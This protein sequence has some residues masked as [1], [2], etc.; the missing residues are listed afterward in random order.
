MKISL[1]V[2]VTAVLILMVTAVMGIITYWNIQT[3]IDNS[4]RDMKRKAK[5]VGRVFGLNYAHSLLTGEA[6]DQTN[7][8]SS[9]LWQNSSEEAIFLIA[10][11]VN[12]NK[13]FQHPK[14]IKNKKH[15]LLPV[16]KKLARKLLRS[17]KQVF[18]RWVEEKYFYDALVPI[19]YHDNDFGIIR[20][21]FDTTKVAHE[22][23]NI[24]I[25]NAIITGIF[26]LFAAIIGF[27][28]TGKLIKPLEKLVRVAKQLGDGE[29]EA[30]SQIS[31]GDEIEELGSVFNNMAEQ[32]QARIEEREKSLEQLHAIQRVGSMLN[33][34]SEPEV[35]FSVL[36]E[37]MQ[38]LYD[39]DA[40][41]P[42]IWD[43]EVFSVP[44]S[45]PKL[46]RPLFM[47]SHSGPLEV[48]DQAEKGEPLSV[49]PE[50]D[51]PETL[52]QM[53]WAYPLKVGI[54]LHGALFMKMTRK[55]S[56][57]EAEW[58]SIWG[59]QVCQA[60]RGMVL[61]GKIREYQNQLV[62]A[63]LD[64]LKKKVR[65]GYTDFLWAEIPDFLSHREEAGMF[66]GEDF[67]D[68]LKDQLKGCDYNTDVIQLKLNEFLIAGEK[69]DNWGRNEIEKIITDFEEAEFKIKWCEKEPD[70]ETLQAF[71]T[72]T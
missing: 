42:F 19:R 1:K 65:A 55:L 62:K 26:W 14:K 37:A 27:W 11:D 61:D 15:R 40:F 51:W 64:L 12:G 47:P 43:G 70:P 49:E 44:Y 46:D 32:I 39:V 71:L 72:K 16:P 29:L 63:Q 3:Q 45:R 52:Q 33:E 69:L 8:I 67:Y 5:L 17:D 38:T 23:Q 57:Q 53:N 28:A 9:R 4:V 13:I 20:L 54:D 41:I 48:V 36:D 6:L 34:S 56:D 68:Q 30:R 10:Y 35:L 21:G 2:K 25:D 59:S 18:G 22:Q 66:Y 24:I 58:M 60:V 50:D 7:K 31:S